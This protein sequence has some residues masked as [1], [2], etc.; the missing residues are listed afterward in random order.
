MAFKC[1]CETFCSCRSILKDSECTHYFREND[2]L[3]NCTRAG[4]LLKKG[5][6]FICVAVDEPYFAQVYGLIQGQERSKGTWTT[7]DDK[8]MD[9]AIEEWADIMEPERSTYDGGSLN[10]A[11]HLKT[12]EQSICKSADCLCCQSDRESL[13]FLKWCLH[14]PLYMAGWDKETLFEK[15]DK[16]K[17]SERLTDKPYMV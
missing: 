6:T 11:E 15:F 16:I 8:A 17:P 5:K 1:Q 10:I 12:F 14:D 2:R 4:K 9:K 3:I 7:E 13:Q